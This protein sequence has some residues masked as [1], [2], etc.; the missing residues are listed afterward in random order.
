MWGAVLPDAPLFAAGLFSWLQTI[1]EYLGLSFVAH[2]DAFYFDSAGFIALHHLL[3][4]PTSLAML[5]CFWLGLKHFERTDLRALW[6]LCGAASHSVVDVITHAEDGILVLW[7]LNWNYRFNSGLDQW[8]MQGAGFWLAAFEATFVVGYG[9]ALLW[10]T[11]KPRTNQIELPK[12]VGY[13]VG[14]MPSPNI[15]NNR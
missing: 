3:H 14:A 15:N 5:L 8:N 7:P 13:S 9:G 1:C 2:M 12:S 10:K 4:S 11:V 6:F